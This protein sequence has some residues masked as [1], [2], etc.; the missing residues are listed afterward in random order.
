MS[1]KNKTSDTSEV[2]YDPTNN[3]EYI[4]YWFFSDD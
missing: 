1:A 3:W 4:S 2:S